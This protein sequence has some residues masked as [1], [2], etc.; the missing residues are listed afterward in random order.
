M[1]DQHRLRVADLED[2][3][4]DARV[5]DIG[6][7]RRRARRTVLV[8]VAARDDAQR[9]GELALDDRTICAPLATVPVTVSATATRPTTTIQSIEA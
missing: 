7:G 5:V 2:R 8:A 9:A 1:L 4:I 3:E 6:V